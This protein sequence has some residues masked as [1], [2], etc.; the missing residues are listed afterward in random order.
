MKIGNSRFAL[1]VIS[2]FIGFGMILTMPVMAEET[3]EKIVAKVDY[4]I[5]TM[6]DLTEASMVLLQQIRENYAPEEWDSRIKE[7]HK[8][9]LMQMINEHVCVRFA[10]ENEI[11]VTDEEI[12]STINKIRENA[13][14]EDEAAF[15]KQLA[16]EGIS[17]DELKE[18]L[19]RQTI[20]RKVMRREV[21]SKIR[22][23]EAEIKNFREENRDQYETRARVRVGVLMLDM[24]SQGLFSKSAVEKKAKEIHE[25]LEKGADFAV[26][27]KEFSDGPATD[28]SGDIGFLEKGKTLPVIE[29]VAFQLEVG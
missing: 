22:V 29:E 17:L 26:L 25:K 3:I 28:N 24:E 10:R 13:G 19:R 16:D 15:R 7:V 9:I 1:I 11:F 8:R 23:T 5:I 4:G 12:D 20:V 21:Q 27:V 6:S 18:T 2:S 14:M